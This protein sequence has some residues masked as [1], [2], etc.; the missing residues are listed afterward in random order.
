MDIF[1]TKPPKTSPLL[2]LPPELREQVFSYAVFSSKPTVTF[3]LDKYQRETY[4]QASQPPLTRV[5]RQIRRESLPLYFE[6]N[7]FV[8]HTEGLKA[9]DAARWLHRNSSHLGRLYCL[10][11]WVRYVAA[12]E[13]TPASGALAVECRH[14]VRSGR[15]AVGEEWKWITVVRRPEG[16]EWDGSLLVMFLNQLVAGRGREG[17]GAEEWVGV[18]E[19]LKRLYVKDKMNQVL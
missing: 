15:W 11:I 2:A 1:A 6:N 17:M 5:S 9:E 4:E 12:N 14:D 19:G 16:V 13:R 10:K 18:L 8:F 3:R 7:A